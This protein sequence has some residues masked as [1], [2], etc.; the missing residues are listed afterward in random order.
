[1]KYSEKTYIGRILKEAILC[2]GD[3]C[4]LNAQALIF[5][6]ISGIIITLTYLINDNDYHLFNRFIHRTTS[7][8]TLLCGLTWPTTAAAYILQR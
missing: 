6:K 2:P 8:Q 5:I 3:G 1:M 7:P 4:T